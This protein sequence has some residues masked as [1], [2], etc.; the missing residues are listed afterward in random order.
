[1]QDI[2]INNQLA[3]SDLHALDS[4]KAAGIDDFSLKLCFVTSATNLPFA[5]TYL[6]EIPTQRKDHHITPMFK[7]GDK[8]LI[9][10]Y[11]PISLLCILLKQLERILYNQVL[12]HIS[13]LF[14]VH[15]FVFS[16]L[17]AMF[18]PICV[19]WPILCDAYG[20][21]HTRMGQYMHMGQNS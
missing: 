16:W 20:T 3:Y 6:Y 13:S 1:M 4:T 15:Q 7:S 5:S 18:C 2:V 8:T 19:Y 9:K 14:I 17:V 21:S 10:N 11:R 12:D